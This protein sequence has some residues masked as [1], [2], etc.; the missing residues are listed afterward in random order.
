MLLHL[1]VK[2]TL[3]YYVLERTSN[4]LFRVYLHH[5]VGSAG[6]YKVAEILR[7]FPAD[8]GPSVQPFNPWEH[9]RHMEIIAI[10]LDGF[11]RP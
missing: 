7:L 3:Y 6:G 4:G 1:C 5:R 10:T 8:V 2:G 9:S 11:W